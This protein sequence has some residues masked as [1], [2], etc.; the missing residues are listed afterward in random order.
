MPCNA[1]IFDVFGTLLKIQHG[2][3]PFRQLFREGLRQGRRPKPSDIHELMTKSLG[4]EEAAEFFGIS[5]SSTRISELKMLLESEVD[6]IEP[7]PDAHDA[8][9]LLMDNDIRVGVCSNLAAPYGRAVKQIF[10]NLD[11]YAFSFELGFIKPNPQI[12]QAVCSMLGVL[13]GDV[14]DAAQRVFM[15]GDSLSCDCLGP[16][17]VGISGIHLDRGGKGGLR[18]LIEFAISAVQQ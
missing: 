2:T 8:I 3:H 1:V 14:D 13:P 11:G 4:I 5:L 15:I 12:Y 10:P 16:R 6:G 18:N 9:A 7:F 17:A